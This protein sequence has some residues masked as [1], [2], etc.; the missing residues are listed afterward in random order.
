MPMCFVHFGQYKHSGRINCWNQWFVSSNLYT[1]Q[2]L[3][4]C[5]RTSTTAVDGNPSNAK[6]HHHYHYI[7]IP[8]ET[9]M[10]WCGQLTRT[11]DI[12]MCL[13]LVCTECHAIEKQTP[14][15]DAYGGQNFLKILNIHK[16]NNVKLVR[17][18]RENS[19]NINLRYRVCLPANVLVWLCVPVCV[20]G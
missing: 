16:I 18:K 10:Q 12:L 19:Y 15:T 3:K 6:H 17:K 2:Y 4:I 9:H 20:C 1:I 11:D 13:Y 7:H 5:K 8:T 14:Q